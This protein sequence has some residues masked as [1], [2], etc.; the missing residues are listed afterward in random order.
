MIIKVETVV[1]GD[2]MDH[3][4]MI[5]HATDIQTYREKYYDIQDEWY[6]KI[7]ACYGHYDMISTF[8]EILEKY[9]ID[10]KDV[11]SIVDGVIVGFMYDE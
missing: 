8:I 1:N 6:A 5:E 2:P 3:F 7:Q 10:A 4:V 11:A 9:N